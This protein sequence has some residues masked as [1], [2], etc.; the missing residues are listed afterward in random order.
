MSNNLDVSIVVLNWNTSDLLSGALESIVETVGTLSYEVIVIDNASTDGGFTQ[1]P[2]RF[3]DDMRF[4]FVQNETNI[5]WAAINR[6]LECSGKYIATVDADAILH[7]GA[8]P[9]LIAFM[10]TH[11]EAGAVTA[12]F[13]NPDGSQ[14]RYFRR[15]LTP[16]LYFFTTPMGR[17][18]DK[19]FLDLKYMQRY[20]YAD[21]DLSAIAE[22]EQPAWP[23]LLWRREALGEYIVDESIPFYFVDVD[24]SKRLYDLGYRIYLVPDT[25]VTHLK[26]TSF[27]KAKDR[28]KRREFYRSL[29]FYFRKHYPYHVPLLFPV[30]WCDRLVRALLRRFLGRE[31]LR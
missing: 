26:S 20:H 29:A 5:G 4:T 16:T 14:Q 27:G 6:M 22:V 15:I 13:R 24:M 12:Q 17:S 3:R 28:W 1:V 31:P 19:Y 7:Q 18:I 11:P 8:L 10:E 21:L 25:V 23:C 9:A 30:L 2:Q